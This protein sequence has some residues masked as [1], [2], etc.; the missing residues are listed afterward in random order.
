MCEGDLLD[1]VKKKQYLQEYEVAMIMHQLL[2][3]LEYLDSL[4]IIHRDLKC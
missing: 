2:S 3:A 1:Y 4:A